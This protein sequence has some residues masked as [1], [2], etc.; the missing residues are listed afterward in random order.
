VYSAMGQ[1]DLLTSIKCHPDDNLSRVVTTNELVWVDPRLRIKPI[2]AWKH[3]RERDRTLSSHAVGIGGGTRHKFSEMDII[4]ISADVSIATFTVL[5]SRKNSLLS[6]YAVST[7]KDSLLQSHALP[8]S[9]SGHFPHGP[10][11]GFHVTHP[12][13]QSGDASTASLIQLTNRG[14]LYQ[15]ALTV[16]QNE[17]EAPPPVTMDVS[18]SPAVHRLATASKAQRP[19]VGKLGT[20]SMQEVDFRQVYQRTSFL[21]SRLRLSHCSKFSP[22]SRTLLST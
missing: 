2:L 6:V 11:A 1:P 12:H 16:C 10:H 7:N 22:L 20:R 18:W 13:P 5:S 3:E 8:Y 4:F 19:D 21:A 14:A 15:T 17:D 9:L